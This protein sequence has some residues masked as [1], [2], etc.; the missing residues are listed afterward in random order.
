MV[1]RHCSKLLLMKSSA[2]DKRG[3]TDKL[4][5]PVFS[6][7]SPIKHICGPSLE[8]S[9]FDGSNEGSQH[10]FLLRIRKIIFKFSIIPPSY[11]ELWKSLTLVYGLLKHFYMTMIIYSPLRSRMFPLVDRSQTQVFFVS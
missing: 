8:S 1:C 7:L 5:I 11:L 10:M 3:N 4:G 9:H 2:S 6:N